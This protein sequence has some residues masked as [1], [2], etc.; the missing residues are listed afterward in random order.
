[1]A[2]GDIIAQKVIEQHPLDIYRTLKNTSFGLFIVGPSVSNW[3][4][5]LHLVVQFK[6]PVKSNSIIQLF[7]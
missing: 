4:K 3:Y 5:L 2:S 6:S 1:M 7:E